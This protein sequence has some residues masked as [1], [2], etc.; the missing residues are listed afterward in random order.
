MVV[1]KNV[2]IVVRKNV[3]IIGV[4]KGVLRVYV[5]SGSGGCAQGCGDMCAQIVGDG[6]CSRMW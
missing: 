5:S 3:V 6:L 2:V 4:L 1:R